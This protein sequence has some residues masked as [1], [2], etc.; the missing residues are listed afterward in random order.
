MALNIPLPN[1]PAGSF[2]EGAK[3]ANALSAQMLENK[4]QQIKNQYA[5]I[6]LPAEAA[7]KLAYAN[8]MGPQFLAK[9]MGNESAVANLSQ[10]QRDQALDIA[11]K[12]GTGQGMTNPLAG[13]L[14]NA[15]QQQNPLMKLLNGIGSM[16]G[17]GQ[18]P[19]QQQ[20]MPQQM[21]QQIVQ[22]PNLSNQDR[23]GI[24]NLQ[25]GGS[26]VVQ[27]NNAPQNNIPSQGDYFEKA[28]K[29]KGKIKQGEES[30]TLRAK[31]IEDLDQQYQQAIQAEVPVQHLIDMTQDPVFMNMRNKIPFFQDKQLKALAKIGTPQEQKAVGDFLTTTTNAVANTVNSFGGR[32]L[33]KE[34]DIADRM[35][36]SPDDTWNVM[37]GKLGSIATF[38]E[39]T[40]KRSRIASRLMQDEHLNRGEAME[41]ADKMID[42]KAI[43]KS[44]EDQLSL[45]P[46]DEDIKYMADKYNISIE[47]VKKR[48][49]KKGHL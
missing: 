16:F 44:V 5:P 45:K 38:N 46:N 21:N 9:L 47:E 24:Q 2:Q 23:A 36:I 32:A 39:M 27:G 3:N 7:S 33:V 30:G 13:I 18:Q 26:Y 40:K 48:L 15:P 1:A 37:V 41:R 49:K 25:P 14:Q 42:G 20:N 29:E 19:Q 4:M 8:L 34:F 28:G 43:R 31:A 22:S 17:G 10:P 12:A 6:T 11:Y 35:K